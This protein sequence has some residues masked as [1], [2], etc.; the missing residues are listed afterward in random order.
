MRNRLALHTAT[1]DTTPL[2]EALHAAKT[3]GWNAIELRRI[4]FVRAAEA[5][6]DEQRVFDLVRGSGLPVACVGGVSG[7]LFGE[8]AEAAPLLRE[9]E[10]SCRRAAALGCQ[11]VMSAVESGTGDVRRAADRLRQVGDFAAAHNVQFALEPQ[12]QA[13]QLNRLA[14]VREIVAVADHPRCGLLLDAYHL[15]RNGELPHGLADLR[16][17]EVV[18]VQYS[19]VPRE[20]LTPGN[21]RP[22]LAPGQGRVDWPAFFGAISALGYTGYVSYEAMNEAAWARDPTE[23]AREALEATRAYL[24]D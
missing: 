8:A 9:V 12:S 24:P 21:T 16:P 4:D 23:V 14:P 22:R 2:A 11:T 18:Y 1:L 10:T 19:D 5:G 15:D 13:A 17:E 6:Q 20:G 7:W 3:A